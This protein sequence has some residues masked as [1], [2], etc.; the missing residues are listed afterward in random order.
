LRGIGR[1]PQSPGVA[2]A[3][4]KVGMGTLRLHVRM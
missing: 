1:D 4:R 3:A 2:L